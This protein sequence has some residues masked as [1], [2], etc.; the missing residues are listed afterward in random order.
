MSDN[1]LPDD[2]F[3]MKYSE[4]PRNC[5]HGAGCPTHPEVPDVTIPGKL[6]VLISQSEQLQAELLRV[7]GRP[8]SHI[9]SRIKAL[10]DA[11]SVITGQPEEM[12]EFR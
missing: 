6:R 1:D 3:Q 4:P 7:V 12:Q 2:E 11:L 10:K 5:C 9:H 8:S